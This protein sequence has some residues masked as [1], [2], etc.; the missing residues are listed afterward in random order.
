MFEKI[1]NSYLSFKEPLIESKYINQET[2]THLLE[3]WS[4]NKK[5]LVN[6]IGRSE[7]GRAIYE[8]RIGKGPIKICMWSQMH[9][10]E[11]TATMALADI[12]N[13]LGTNSSLSNELFDLINEK[14][15]IHIIPVVNPDG[16]YYWTRETSLGIDMNRDARKLA[17]VEGK[18]LFEWIS[19]IQP[20]FSLNLHDQNRLYSVGKTEEQS[21]FAF[22]APPLDDENTWTVSREK[23]AKIANRLIRLTSPYFP[24]KIA[25][26][27]DEFE[28]RAFGDT[29]QKLGFGVLL[30]EAGG[31][32]YDFN[33]MKLRE[34]EAAILAEILTSISLNNWE[35]DGLDL[36]HSLSI[37]ARNIFDLKIKNVRINH[38][39]VDLGFNIQEIWDGR[40]FKYNW[41]LEELGDLS[42]YGAL[43]E[44][45]NE[46]NSI[47][48]E[49]ILG[50]EYNNI[51]FCNSK[52]KRYSLEEILLKI[53]QE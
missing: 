36:Y 29:L 43:N 32:K 34:F 30:I 7:E 50:K 47:K 25:K 23:S 42:I 52:S 21:H 1:L 40:Q 12:F 26:W 18:L 41:I 46:S 5:I 9:G 20:D 13:L 11:A 44:W 28:P 3:K 15:S 24:N 8:I 51:E 37:N 16:A 35:E 27:S 2:W 4:K 33:K 49:L 19:Q 31:M 14:L 10:N 22:L 39:I 53:N 17:S 6:E 45:D 38:S 48:E